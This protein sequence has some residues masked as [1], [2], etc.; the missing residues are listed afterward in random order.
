MDI[1]QLLAAIDNTLRKCGVPGAGLAIVD[2]KGISR[3]A[4]DPPGGVIPGGASPAVRNRR[5]LPPA[6][7][8][9]EMKRFELAVPFC[10]SQTMSIS[11]SSET[12]RRIIYIGPFV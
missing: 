2:G 5:T 11:I 1:K 4:S 12:D 10:V 7:Y 3:A 9:A 8:A 6:A